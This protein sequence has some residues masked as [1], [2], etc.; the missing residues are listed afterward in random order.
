VRRKPL[1]ECSRRWSRVRKAALTAHV[2]C[3]V[4]W[5]GAVVGSL[6]LAIAGLI[7]RR[8]AEDAGHLPRVR[9]DRWFALVPLSMASLATG[10]VQSLGTK[11]GLFRYWWVVVK[12]VITVIA[13]IVLL[14]YT[15]TLGAL[16]DVTREPT[17]AGGEG[18]VLPSRR[19]CCTPRLRCCFCS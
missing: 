8:P 14:L 3:S 18:D 15:Q 9:G 16:A 2:V 13:V 5:L 17:T 1:P 6:A 4:G 10:V 19:R 12:L 11:W 7:H